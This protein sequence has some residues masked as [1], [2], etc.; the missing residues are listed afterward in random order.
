M[1]LK[2]TVKSGKNDFNF[3]L[4]K[5]KDKYKEKTGI[6]LFPGTLNVH[7]KETKFKT[8]YNCMF[9]DFGELNDDIS[10]KIIKCKI[11]GKNAFILRPVSRNFKDEY[12]HGDEYDSIL[13]IASDIKL[14]DAYGLKDGDMVEV[15]IS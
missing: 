1:I 7:L 10:V 14:R 12:K 2:G 8:P 4:E 3:W 11:F 15:E 9:F 5:F 6:K 13:E